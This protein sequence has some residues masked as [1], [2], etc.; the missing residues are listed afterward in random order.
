MT[1]SP[2]T[3]A[4]PTG[5]LIDELVDLGVLDA[6][7]LRLA[8]LLG[9]TWAGSAI[10]PLVRLGAALAVRAPRLGHVC[11]DLAVVSASVTAEV[12]QR[13]GGAR[14]A[15]ESL[16]GLEWPHLDA[17]REALAASGVVSVAESDDDWVGA[18][19]DRPFVLSGTRLYLQR[20]WT[21]EADVADRLLAL[22]SADVEVGDALGVVS[23]LLPGDAAADQRR[24][25]ERSLAHRLGVIAGGPGTGKTTTIAALLVAA[26]L[27]GGAN[28]ARRVDD[29][30][31]AAGPDELPLRVVLAAPTGKAAARVNDALRSAL[32]AFAA[33]SPPEI[34]DVLP[35]VLT[36]LDE[37][38]ATTLHRLLGAG[39]GPT[40]SFRHDQRNPLPYDVVVVDE[41]S[42][43]ALPMM[44]H[45]L[46]AIAPGARL[47]LVGD[48]HQLASVEAGSVLA[49][50]VGPVLAAAHDDPGAAGADSPLAGAV[51][52]LR[53]NF[54]FAED[55]GIAALAA[56]VNAGD[57]AAVLAA[58]A[59]GDGVRWHDADP[60][61]PTGRP[62][63]LDA[64]ADAGRSV[65]DAARA[66]D[67]G[68]ALARLGRCQ[69]LCAHR[70]GPYG[71]GQWNRWVGAR[72][73]VSAVAP[74][75]RPVLV[76]RNDPAL[77]VFNGDVGVEV[78]DT[79]RRRVVF[80]ATAPGGGATGEVRSLAPVQLEHLE[81]AHALTIHKSQGSEF[82]EV[83]V[84]LPPASSRLASRELLYTA[85]TRARHGVAVI[86]T[87]DAVRA[88]VRRRL[89][90]QGGLAARL[91]GER[92]SAPA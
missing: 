85:V 47:V 18:D 89:T 15:E 70:D 46:D 82:D 60:A 43:V 14:A 3:A 41:A 75:G 83:V 91:W 39:G 68:S 12:P 48:P 52:V 57:D 24:A 53:Q 32:A 44:A 7:D 50:I 56:A 13:A 2:P 34:A 69:L 88:A 73:G 27:A 30:D 26:H 64:V 20:Y 81:V 29:A 67:A 21:Q 9:H 35:A 36:A 55:S 5:Q 38:E 72:L 19:G 74:A 84:V 23:A 54:R 87:A 25:V 10:D 92:A 45:L 22:S 62:A 66:G 6:G 37:V 61:G 79:G 28:A 1:T 63:V 17:W 78:L 51:S 11:C 42:M 40:A 65:V 33:A 31:G 59:A 86:G 71:V 8:D 16:G 4:G 76:T 90:R 77:G 80:A 58:L 49:D